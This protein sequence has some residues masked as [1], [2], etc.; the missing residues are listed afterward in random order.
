MNKRLFFALY[1][2]TISNAKTKKIAILMSKG[3]E[4]IFFTLYGI[5]AVV[6][7][8]YGRYKMLLRYLAVP[9]I[10]L[11]YN[12]FLRK[13]LKKPRPFVKENGVESLTGNKKSYSCPSNHAASAMVIAMAWYCIYPPAVF[14]LCLLA[15]A[16]G[17]SRVMTGVHYPFDVALG[18]IIGALA[19]LIGFSIIF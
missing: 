3:A 15:F 14:V 2:M 1:N 19:G 11:L 7:L 16:T 4:L 5:G 10:T 9:F 17:L 8:F 12:T 6:I 18:W 13:M